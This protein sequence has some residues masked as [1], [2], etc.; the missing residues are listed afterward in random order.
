MIASLSGILKEKTDKYLIIDV[1]GIGYQVFVSTDLLAQTLVVGSPIALSIYMAIRENSMELFGFETT[2]EKHLFELLLSVSGI[3]PRSALSI[4]SIAP[5]ETIKRAIGSGD[6]SYLT[7]VSGIG[8]KTAEK[9]VVELRDKL[10][11]LGHTDE[12]GSLRGDSDV[13]EALQ[14]LGYTLNDAR[15]AVKEISRAVTGTNERIKEALKALGR[16]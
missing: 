8:R 9:I 4:L 13:I 6:T 10:A 2:D 14:A 15:N 7:K 11:A 5:L 16:K 3:G 1:N 12:T